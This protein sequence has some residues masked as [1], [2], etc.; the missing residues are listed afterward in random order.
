MPPMP[1]DLL[2]G[3]QAARL[4]SAAGSNSKPRD[5]AARQP[6]LGRIFGQ[7]LLT[8]SRQQHFQ[9]TLQFSHRRSSGCP[10]RKLRICAGFLNAPCLLSGRTVIEC[11]SLSPREAGRRSGCNRHGSPNHSMKAARW[12]TGSCSMRR[13]RK[14]AWPG[15]GA[16]FTA[17]PR[18]A[19]VA[20]SGHFDCLTCTRPIW[21]HAR[22]RSTRFD[23]QCEAKTSCLKISIG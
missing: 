23:Y 21:E 3:R 2:A 15:R 17:A 6:E 11:S 19:V 5:V 7:F 20:P 16:R 12:G 14:L 10:T 8:R 22:K 9:T 4:G 13:P 18:A 1:R